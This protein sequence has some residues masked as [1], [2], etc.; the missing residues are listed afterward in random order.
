[1]DASPKVEPSDLLS[2][3][4]KKD[5]SVAKPFGTFRALSGSPK[6]EI[7]VA[8][9]KFCVAKPFLAPFQNL[10]GTCLASFWALFG[11][12]PGGYLCR[13]LGLCL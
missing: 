7:C 2:G 10:T 13:E 1:M 6:E 5:I 9:R 12:S 8:R 4:L 11:N 3:K